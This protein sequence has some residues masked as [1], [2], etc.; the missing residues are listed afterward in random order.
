MK[1]R[2][3]LSN[4]SESF[5]QKINEKAIINVTIK[6]NS[7]ATIKILSAIFSNLISNCSFDVRID[8]KE[9]MQLAINKIHATPV[10]SSILDTSPNFEI[11]SE[12]NTTRQNPNKL[13][14]V[15]RIC[16]VLMFVIVISFMFH[17]VSFISPCSP[18]GI[19]KFTTEQLTS[20]N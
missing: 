14:D 6:T 3:S 1:L 19:D 20:A 8:K 13:E 9:N 15:L 12:V 18:G 11:L 10:I 2:T 16:C 7:K 17:S 4:L 5:Y